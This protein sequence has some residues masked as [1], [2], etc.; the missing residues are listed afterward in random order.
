[1]A[2]AMSASREI[3]S[4]AGAMVDAQ[5]A[6]AVSRRFRI[7]HVAVGHAAD[8][9]VDAKDRL[10]VLEAGFP[11][12]V[13]FALDDLERDPNV[14]HDLHLNRPPNSHEVSPSIGRHPLSRQARWPGSGCKHAMA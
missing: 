6:D 10:L 12:P 5:L 13:D 1:M 9:G 4:V 11:A 14:N 3:D 8:S 2:R 7:A